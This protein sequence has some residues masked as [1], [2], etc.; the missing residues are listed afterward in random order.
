MYCLIKVFIFSAKIKKKLYSVWMQILASKKYV[1]IWHWTFNK[2]DVQILHFMVSFHEPCWLIRPFARFYC[3]NGSPP[4]WNNNASQLR[5]LIQKEI[6]EGDK[7]VLKRYSTPLP[8]T[9]FS[10]R[11][12]VF[13]SI[14]THIMKLWIDTTILRP[15]VRFPLNSQKT[16]S[17]KILSMEPIRRIYN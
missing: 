15:R 11:F 17:S 2:T 4:R 7:V 5:Y 13:C 6:G 12:R 8:P 9:R 1:S 14:R 16:K 3:R 10:R